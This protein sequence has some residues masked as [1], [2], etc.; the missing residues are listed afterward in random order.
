MR[1]TNKNKGQHSQNRNLGKTGQ[2]VLLLWQWQSWH[3]TISRG[4]NEQLV[5]KLSLT[6]RITA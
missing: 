1:L 4:T 2:K 6:R 5:L 3:I